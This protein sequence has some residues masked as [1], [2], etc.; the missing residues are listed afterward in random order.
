MTNDKLNKLLTTQAGCFDC[1]NLVCQCKFSSQDELRRLSGDNAENTTAEV[2]SRPFLTRPA[3]I[4]WLQ[5][6]EFPEK[7]G[8][9]NYPQLTLSLIEEYRVEN[10]QMDQTLRF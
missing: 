1:G 10:K 4:D 9:P 8:E 6:A 3:V 2:V 5:W 7:L